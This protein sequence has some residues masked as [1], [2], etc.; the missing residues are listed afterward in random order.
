MVTVR[1]DDKRW[2]ELVFVD[3][4]EFARRRIE[5]PKAKRK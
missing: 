3:D 1:R 5:L 2:M 4:A